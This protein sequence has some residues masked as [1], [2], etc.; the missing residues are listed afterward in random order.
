MVIIF[1]SYFFNPTADLNTGPSQDQVVDHDGERPDHLVG[2]GHPCP[3]G[4]EAQRRA[5]AIASVS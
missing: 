1:A 5:A 4:P 2:D 3:V